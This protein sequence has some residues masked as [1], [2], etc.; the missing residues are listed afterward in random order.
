MAEQSGICVRRID[1]GRLTL[2]IREIGEGPLAIFLHGITSNSA[3]WDPILFNLKDRLHSVAIDQRGHGLSDKPE[4]GYEAEDYA[5]DVIALIEK[6]GL[7]RAIL[8]GN[9]LGARNSIVTAG[10]RPDLIQSVIAIDFTPF[11]EREVMDALE[12]RVKAG[13]RTFR[14]RDEI[15]AYLCDRYPLMPPDAIRRRAMSAYES[16]GAELRPRAVP[17]AMMQ[18]VIGL[19]E[20]LESALKAVTRPVLIVRGAKSKFVS[21]EA[22]EKTRHLRPDLPTLVVPNV[23]HYV[24]EEA[25]EVITKAIFDFVAGNIASHPSP[26]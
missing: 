4:R 3:I 22:F 15:E 25:P 13:D 14:S 21:V 20:E 9:S 7:G 16:I 12:T 5:R 10:L 6:L 19:R 26:K 8:I 23:D 17:A 11:I 2:N 18:T 24:N 1:V